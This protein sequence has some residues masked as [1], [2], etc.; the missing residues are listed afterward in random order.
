MDAQTTIL[1]SPKRKPSLMS[2]SGKKNMFTQDYA[3]DPMVLTKEGFPATT[4]EIQN[5]RIETV[6][7]YSNKIDLVLRFLHTTVR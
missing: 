5:W 1:P 2:G 3:D 6:L 7:S 4:R